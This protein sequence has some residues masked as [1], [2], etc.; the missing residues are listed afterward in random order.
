M[1]HLGWLDFA[2]LTTLL[3]TKCTHAHYI[4]EVVHVHTRKTAANHCANF[5]SD[6]T[7]V[8]SF[9]HFNLLPIPHCAETHAACSRCAQL[10]FYAKSE[11][12]SLVPQ[13]PS[14]CPSFALYVGKGGI[15][16]PC[17][18]LAPLWNLQ[19]LCE[20]WEQNQ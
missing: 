14:S 6:N 18:N 20:V 11:I 3:Q 7:C 16:T 4:H 2:C 13:A 15:C 1:K 9:S 19:T 12:T 5:T 8:G 17:Q 10:N